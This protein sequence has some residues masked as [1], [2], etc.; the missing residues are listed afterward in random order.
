[1]AVWPGD[2]PTEVR[3]L[4][5]IAAGDEYNLSGWVVGN[6][7]GTHVDPP[8]HMIQ[9]GKSVAEMDLESLCGPCRVLDLTHVTTQ[10]TAK[11]LA[12]IGNAKR[13]LL[14]TPN[15]FAD[16]T[17]FHEE[18]VSLTL[19]AAQCLVQNGVRLLGTDG[20][21]IEQFVAHGYPVHQAILGAEIA[22]VEGLSLSH[23]EPG[24]YDLICAPLRWVD[25]D[26][27]PCR[28]LLRRV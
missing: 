9:G 27:S 10:V 20:P 2:Q 8:L 3:P 13:V 11:D 18:Y 23:I 21:S 1:M 14:K 25:G 24:E 19:E 15:S 7:S 6:H 5:R 22:V 26:G 16:P 12:G 28:A 17:V 4:F